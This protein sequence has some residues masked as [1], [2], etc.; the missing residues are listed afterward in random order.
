MNNENDLHPH[1]NLDNF[2]EYLV[3]R[4]N[5]KNSKITKEQADDLHHHAETI[6]GCDTVE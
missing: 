4:S 5:D 2:Y 3:R 1:D 6:L